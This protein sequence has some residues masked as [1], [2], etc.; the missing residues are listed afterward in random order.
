MS[1]TTR[2][3]TR[4]VSDEQLEVS[5]PHS[6]PARVDG[7]ANAGPSPVEA[8]LGAL[9][10]CTSIDVVEIMAKR[11]TPV[12]KLEVDA[13]GERVDT[14][15]KRLTQITLTFRVGGQGVEKDQVE[16]AVDLSLTKYCSVRA[17]LDPTIPIAW[18]VELVPV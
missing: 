18:T 8:L 7:E 13:V 15:P 6:A 1:I 5:G 9:A 12:G 14:H 3:F 4:W 10:T 2:A 16:R 17:S 11:R